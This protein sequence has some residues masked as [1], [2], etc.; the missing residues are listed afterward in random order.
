MILMVIRRG[1]PSARKSLATQCWPSMIMCTA[2]E[3]DPA[4]DNQE[5]EVDDEVTEQEEQWREQ[6]EQEERSEVADTT[7]ELKT[8]SLKLSS[9]VAPPFL[10]F[11]QQLPMS[12]ENSAAIP[13]TF[14]RPR[15]DPRIKAVGEDVAS[16]QKSLVT[17]PNLTFLLQ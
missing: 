5:E 11:P 1:V 12:C 10:P 2:S 17:P 14:W 4:W 9:C 16:S 8:I 6:Q 7:E 13:A 3:A 15:E